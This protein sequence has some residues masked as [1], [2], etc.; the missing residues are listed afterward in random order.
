[1]TDD[2]HDGLGLADDAN[3]TTGPMISDDDVFQQSEYFTVKKQSH[4]TIQPNMKPIFQLDLKTVP[5][6]LPLS[7]PFGGLCKPAISR[8]GQLFMTGTEYQQQENNFNNRL[9]LGQCLPP[10]I[11]GKIDDASVILHNYSIHEHVRD[12]DWL[13]GDEKRVVAALNNNLGIVVLSEDLVRIEDIVMFPTFHSDT[14]R[15][16][17]VNPMNPS[18]VISGGFDGKVFVT[19]ISRLVHDIQKM[20]KKSENSVYMCHDVV[21]SVRWHP[22]DRN[23]ASCTT[24]QGVLHVFD[25]RTD[26]TKPA[27]VYSANG[28]L[29]LYS[30]AYM[31][32]FTVCLG[33]GDG[34][35]EIHDIRNGKGLIG[36]RDPYLSAIGE[37]CFEW[38]SSG[39]GHNSPTQ[40]CANFGAGAVSVWN[41][42]V[43]ASICHYGRHG[44][45][46]TIHSTGVHGYVTAGAFIPHHDGYMAVTDSEGIYAVYDVSADMKALQ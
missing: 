19:D 40:K 37:I 20:E 2:M 25:I 43:D 4:D 8:T 32:D 28:K 5:N 14:I 38:S 3:L 34:L 27:F 10:T 15:N 11:T 12:L 30:H 36:Y 35:I 41:F 45:L 24:D 16:I 17:A 13:H 39:G 6:L 31:D 21:G 42:N 29:E 23:V 26:Q 22:S 1:M 7:N 44:P 46:N 18:L 9:I 33:Y